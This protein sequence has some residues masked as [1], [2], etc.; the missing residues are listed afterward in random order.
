[1]KTVDLIQH[2]QTARSPLVTLTTFMSSENH[3]RR[4]MICH[5]LSLLM[6]SLLP[7]VGTKSLTALAIA[8]S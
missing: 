1:M 2:T 5:I 8:L 7:R 4:F 3:S 6:T